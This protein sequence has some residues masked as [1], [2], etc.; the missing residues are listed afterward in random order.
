TF[1]EAGA[2][3]KVGKS[4]IENHETLMPLSELC[5]HKKA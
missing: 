3:M 2:S 1:V 5:G 4:C